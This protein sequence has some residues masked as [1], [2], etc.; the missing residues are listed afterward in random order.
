MP[1][2]RR[3]NCLRGVERK[4]IKMSLELS[5]VQRRSA[6]ETNEVRQQSHFD[7]EDSKQAYDVRSYLVLLITV[8]RF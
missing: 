8:L 5:T 1:I 3:L 6:Q 7:E 2:F 4:T